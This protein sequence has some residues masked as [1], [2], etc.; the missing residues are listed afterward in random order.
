MNSCLNAPSAAPLEVLRTKP[1]AAFLGI[2]EA[3]LFKLNRL[4]QG[5]PRSRLGRMPLYRISDLRQWLQ[6]NLEQ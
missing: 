4:K 2:S 1:A 5:P 6:E 3:Q